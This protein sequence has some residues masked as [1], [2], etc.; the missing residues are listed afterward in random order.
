MP[1]PNQIML[2]QLLEMLVLESSSS[3]QPPHSIFIKATMKNLTSVIMAEAVVMALALEIIIALH[4]QQVS[5]LLD[6]KQL[7]HFINGSDLTH[8]PD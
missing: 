2:V 3:M 4:I 1:P 7:V 5:I 6:N 8:P